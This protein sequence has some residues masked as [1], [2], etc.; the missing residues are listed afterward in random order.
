MP[1]GRRKWISK[2]Q[3]VTYQLSLRP[4]EGGGEKVVLTPVKA[5]GNQ[6]IPDE[7]LEDLSS[8]FQDSPL[9]TDEEGEKTRF[10]H[11]DNDNEGQEEGGEE[12]QFDDYDS[13][14]DELEIMRRFT[15]QIGTV[16][17]SVFITPEGEILPATEVP[18]IDEDIL[19][20]IEAEV[21]RMKAILGVRDD[22]EIDSD[23][24]E[25]LENFDETKF[26]GFGDDFLDVI[27][28][29]AREQAE[30][31]VE[32][33]G[34]YGLDDIEGD[35][36]DD[37]L[38][39]KYTKTTTTTSVAR[40]DNVDSDNE[41]DEDE[42]EEDVDSHDEKGKK[43]RRPR[44]NKLVDDM[45]D[46]ALERFDEDDTLNLDP[47]DPLINGVATTMYFKEVYDSFAE[48][49]T[50]V[51]AQE[52]DKELGKKVIVLPPPLVDEEGLAAADTNR[53]E[54][55]KN[56]NSSEEESDDSDADWKRDLTDK[57]EIREKDTAWDCESIISTYSNTEN[58]PSLI[59]IPRNEEKIKLGTRGAPKLE[60]KKEKKEQPSE[61]V[62]T[63]NLGAPRTKD[64][65]PEQKRLR[66]Q[67]T[68]TLRKEKR[69]VKKGNRVAFHEEEVRQKTLNATNF[70]RNKTVLQYSI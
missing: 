59:A 57:L 65:T 33:G 63:P 61:P 49:Y 70:T 25:A 52:L 27:L 39:L 2:K 17:G 54:S 46:V 38:M 36:D 32:V 62:V 68:R 55:D 10:N 15:R 5:Y 43:Q 31:I 40:F 66:K 22:E 8:R 20:E 3:A 53:L 60:H 48:K 44:E 16:S 50:K 30:E 42:D 64:E 12:G 37:D 34:G 11:E 29:E 6:N 35:E 45:F 58:H 18:T 56:N 9:P 24:E 69:Q 26:E 14:D 51:S 19:A 7:M 47:D 41:E 28:S 23:I 4:A 67:G 13:D 21:P 1:R